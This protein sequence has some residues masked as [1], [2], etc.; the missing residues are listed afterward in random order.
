MTMTLANA[1]LFVLVIGGILLLPL[2][3]SNVMAE[4]QLAKWRRRARRAREVS[5]GEN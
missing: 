4:I 2:F 5:D 1:W 3:V